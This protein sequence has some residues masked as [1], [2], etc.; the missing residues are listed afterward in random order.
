M[1]NMDWLRWKQGQPLLPTAVEDSLG[2]WEGCIN[3]LL[4]KGSSQTPMPFYT[5]STWHL[6]DFSSAFNPEVIE[7]GKLR[8]VEVE[9]RPIIVT[10]SFC[11]LSR[12]IGGMLQ[13]STGQGKPDSHAII[14]PQ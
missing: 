3:T 13:H 9:V 11:R 4:V 10:Q 12:H 5:S 7:H 6:M 8:W 1:A 14:P 2:I